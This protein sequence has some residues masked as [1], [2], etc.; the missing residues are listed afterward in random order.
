LDSLD[1][2]GSSDPCQS[3]QCVN[4][5][6]PPRSWGPAAPIVSTV[7]SVSRPYCPSSQTGSDEAAERAAVQ[8]EPEL[9]IEGTA[10]RQV[11]GAAWPIHKCSRIATP[12]LHIQTDDR[13]PSMGASF[14]ALRHWPT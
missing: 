5:V 3:V 4:N 6:G 11:A 7:S 10:K 9:P 12:R 14:V 2:L 1:T 8:A 13:F